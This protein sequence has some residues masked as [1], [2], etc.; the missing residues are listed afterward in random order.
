MHVQMSELE[1]R[2]LA[3]ASR[4]LGGPVPQSTADAVRESIESHHL[5]EAN[6]WL[7]PLLQRLLDATPTP[8]PVEIPWGYPG[9]ENGL[10]NLLADLEGQTWLHVDDY[11][12]GVLWRLPA[13]GLEVFISRESK[14]SVRD[15]H[16]YEVRRAVG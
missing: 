13:A 12:E 1:R 14:A 10:A 3:I 4:E 9:G 16:T 6:D 15:S 5:W 11:G 8:G 7:I 2:V